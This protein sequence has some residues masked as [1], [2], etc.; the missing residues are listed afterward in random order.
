M[1]IYLLLCFQKSKIDIMAKVKTSIGQQ[2]KDALDGRTNRWLSI[3]T[4]IP[5]SE[6]SKKINDKSDFTQQEITTIN[7]IL[8][9]NIVL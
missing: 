2:V 5:E 6:L 3:K 7:K 9:S 4:S 8:N 1:E